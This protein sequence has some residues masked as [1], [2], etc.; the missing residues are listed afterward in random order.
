[1]SFFDALNVSASGLTAERLR[2]DVTA[3]NLANAE[4]TQGPNGKPYQR[5][6]VELRSVGGDFGNTL[7]QAM[8]GSAA[9]PGGV[10]VTG[11]VADKTPD[12]LVYDP[13]APGANKAGYVRMP[14]V[15]SVTEMTDLIDESDTYQSDV[16]AMSTSKTMYSDTLQLLK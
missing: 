4:T 9:P 6:E 1:M 11:I 12:Q 8:G 7:A 3:E 16:T 13:G 5:Q 14:N 15:N 2:M 10:E